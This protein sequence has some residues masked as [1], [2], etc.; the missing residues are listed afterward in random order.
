MNKPIPVDTCRDHGENDSRS[1]RA[2]LCPG[3]EG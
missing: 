3:Q 2:E 1:R